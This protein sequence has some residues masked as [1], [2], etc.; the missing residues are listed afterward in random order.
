VPAWGTVSRVGGRRS[1]AALAVAVV[2]VSGCA[3]SRG[4]DGTPEAAP[5]ERLEPSCPAPSAPPVV[6]A[7]LVN[8]VVARA[9]LP[10]WQA[11][12]IG[13]SA[14]L[15]DGRLVWVF[16]DTVR[17][18]QSTV[19][20]VANSLLLSS[21]TCISQV[22]PDGDGP[23]I[24]DVDARTVRWPMSVVV[25][26]PS[27]ELAAQGADD[28]VVVLCART[29][30]GTG[31]PLDFEFR[32]TSAAVLTV[33]DGGAPQL[34][35]ILEITPDDGAADQV[36]WGAAAT[37]SGD[38]F[39]VYGTRLTGRPMTFGREL[40]VASVPVEDPTDR[41]RWRF[42]DGA[43]WQADIAEAAPVLAAEGG[44]SQ[45]LSVD[46]VDGTWL[47]VSKRDGD[48][49]D[50]VYTWSAPAP[51]GPWTPTRALESPAGFDTGE[52]TYAPLAH[53]EITLQSG[54]L[55]VSISRNTTDLGRLLSDPEVGR[56]LFAEVPRP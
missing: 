43:R 27:A 39:Y 29:R 33:A 17:T 46:E 56:P 44:V 19:R 16:G 54:Q 24:P 38:R 51:T 49:S 30:R 48:I 7:D 34:R 26:P 35:E 41:A 9:D 2:L 23:V 20:I 55:L 50:F 1:G 8:Q 28:V 6:S 3:P 42:W 14:R 37:V 12:D 52:L 4:D 31:G 53:P 18:P 45:T 11:G 40:Y 10:L 13:A 36:D 5:A 25:L 15:S 21:G 22:L 47:A 32:G